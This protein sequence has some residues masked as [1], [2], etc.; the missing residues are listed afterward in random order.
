M[1]IWKL[2]GKASQVTFIKLAI[3]CGS[4]KNKIVSANGAGPKAVSVY[5]KGN[6][7]ARKQQF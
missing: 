5:R 3:L 7:K 4:R 2:A 1:S 6:V